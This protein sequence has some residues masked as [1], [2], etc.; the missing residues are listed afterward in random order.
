MK[1]FYVITRK[2]KQSKILGDRIVQLLTNSGWQFNEENPYLIISVGGDGTLLHAVHH[3]IDRID[4]VVFVGIHTGTLGFFTDY[5]ESE[6]DNL[7]YDLTK[8][9]LTIERIPLLKATRINQNKHE[10]LYALNEIRVEN[11]IKTQRLEVYLNQDYLQ[12]FR[13][14]G[15]CISGQ[16][17]STAYNRSLHGAVIM[18]GIDIM[19]ITEVSGIHHKASKSL[20]SPLVV[21][22]DTYV[23]LKSESFNDSI[24]CYD[25]LHVRLDGI[26]EVTIS[27][28]EAYV[29]FARLKPISYVT[30]LKSLF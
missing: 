17:G 30:R 7:V 25:H 6:I 3:Y 26:E 28:G 15:L 11:I 1:P 8:K 14:N 18:P 5:A 9:E 19:Q 22:S 4:Q 24:L 27:S 29:Q 13:G 21:S 2:D 23:R 12:T 10:D 20:G 16:A